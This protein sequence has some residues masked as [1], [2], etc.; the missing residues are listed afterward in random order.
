M[1][2]R[3][4]RSV[5]L[6]VAL[7][8][9][10]V[11]IVLL[12]MRLPSEL[13]GSRP[14]DDAMG[15]APAVASVAA[16]I[17]LV[18][19][20]PASSVAPVHVDT[21]TPKRSDEVDTIP[22]AVEIGGVAAHRAGYAVGLKREAK[23]GTVAEVLMLDEHGR[24]TAVLSLGPLRGDVGPPMLAAKG[25]HL[26]ASVLEPNA[27]G[28]ARRMVAIRDGKS[29]WGAEFELG[30]TESFGADLVVGPDDTFIVYDDLVQDGKRSQISLR[31]VT[32]R[33]A[34]ANRKPH[35]LSAPGIDAEMPRMV[36]R[37]GGYWLAYV[38]R[39]RAEDKPVRVQGG[40]K[41]T[42]RYAAE[43]IEPSRIEIIPLDEEAR[44]QGEA[45]AVTP[46]R[47]HVLAYDLKAV[48]DD[49]LLI[50]WRDDDTPSGSG[51][52]E[53]NVLRIDLSGVGER[54]LVVRDDIGAGVPQL[55]GSWLAYANRRDELRMAHLDD[56]GLVG[57]SLARPSL[58]PRA[59]WL[60]GRGDDILLVQP[61]GTGVEFSLLRCRQLSR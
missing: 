19:C 50:A 42:G 51:G 16:S 44:P 45:R 47:G 36:E 55:V 61:R 9:L 32:T 54:Q 38:A 48:A 18:S 7:S 15:S 1:A 23:E 13:T 34:K 29:Y 10:S 21:H 26:I 37:A 52:G 56:R 35:V 60:V 39:G 8:V 49:G 5:G 11:L 59:Q 33:D 22:F 40:A 58:F 53:L 17:D 46:L 28:I 2:D 30:R 25:E 24:R 31:S 20:A 57:D 27:S 41:P 6:W 12:L 3:Q 4:E 14:T 43:A